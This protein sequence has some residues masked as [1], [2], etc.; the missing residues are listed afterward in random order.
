MENAL[1]PQMAFLGIGNIGRG[2]TKNLVSKTILRRPLLL[3]NRTYETAV[4]HSTAIGHSEAIRTIEE[5]VA[6]SDVIWS[7]LSNQEAVFEA[8]EHALKADV[9]GKLFVESSTL[10]PAATNELGQMTIH[11]GAEFV[12]MP[13]F[14]EPSMAD[15]GILTCVPCGK[16]ESV[17]RIRPYLV[18]G[19]ARA[20]IDLS[21]EK[22][23]TA[24]LLK[25]VGNTFILNTM[26]MIAEGHVFAEKTGLGVEILQ[27]LIATVFPAGPS[28]TYSKRM[29]SGDYSQ[30]KPMA[31]IGL[32]REI[33]AHVLKVA[34]E[35]GVCLPAYETTVKHLAAVDQ[36]AG[37][38]YDISAIY[39]VVRLESG[40]SFDN[41]PDHSMQ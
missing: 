34:D 20:I 9:M 37:A 31:S 35:A 15:A 19:V 22:P 27:K 28:M 6:R 32:A 17:N 41:T 40:L 33:A 25:L 13:V 23:G 11:A 10:T 8:F 26:E 29:S 7:C 12:A 24:S 18:G 21:D 5:A 16:A 1:E 30:G 39:G 2:M 36:R 38:H 3:W 14:G 4:D